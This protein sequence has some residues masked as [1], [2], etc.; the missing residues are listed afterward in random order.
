MSTNRVATGQEMVREKKFFK[1][2][3]KSRNFIFES[4]KIDILV[5]SQ[6]K[7]QKFNT[8]DF[9][10]SLASKREH[11]MPKHALIGCQT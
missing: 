4:V 6:E 7:L 11:V 8:A 2:R 5:K 9:I 10:P 1:F 3:E